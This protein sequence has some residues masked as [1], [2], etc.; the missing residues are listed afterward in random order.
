MRGTAFQLIY[1]EAV[2]M[3]AVLIDEREVTFITPARGWEPG[4]FLSQG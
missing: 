3:P 4:T 2:L 1:G